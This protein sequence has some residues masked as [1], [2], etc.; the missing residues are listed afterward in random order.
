MEIVPEHVRAGREAVVRRGL[1]ERVD[2]REGDITRDRAPGVFDVVVVSNVLEH[3]T[4]RAALLRRWAEWYGGAGGAARFLVRV[5]A[6]DRDW[7]VPFKKSLGVEW[8][9]DVTHETEYTLTELRAELEEGGLEV[10]ELVAN[11]GEYWVSAR[12]RGADAARR[13]A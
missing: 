11:W 10:E 9:L 5:P 6:F 1:G 13:V 2:L 3:L 7:R 12:V 4:D 8:R